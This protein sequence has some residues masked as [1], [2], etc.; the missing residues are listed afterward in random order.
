MNKSSDKKT[1]FFTIAGIVLFVI[2]LQGFASF[3]LS[4]INRSSVPIPRRVPRVLP[5]LPPAA[6]VS[7]TNN[8]MVLG[9]DG[10]LWAKGDNIGGGL[11]DNSEIP[12]RFFDQVG[13]DT[14][15]IS[16]S[17]GRDHTVAIKADGTLWAWG[18]NGREVIRNPASS[19]LGDGTNIN[20]LTPV[21]IGTDIDWAMVAAGTGH[22]VA[23]RAN[24]TLWFWGTKRLEGYESKRSLVP[25]QVGNDTDWAYIVAGSGGT[26]M[27]KIDGTLWAWGENKHGIMGHGMLGVGSIEVLPIPTQVAENTT[28]KA[29]DIGNLHS[30][31]IQTDGSLWAWGDNSQGNLGDGTREPSLYPIQIGTCTDWVSV[32]AGFG[33][34][35]ATREDGSLWVWGRHSLLFFGGLA[36]RDSTIPTQI[37]PYEHWVSVAAGGNNRAFA[38]TIDGRVQRLG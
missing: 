37:H 12:R 27:L 4:F 21:Q 36:Q 35:I 30:A 2:F 9:T 19:P 34:T 17:A 23:I 3:S 38:I 13:A 11:G 20:R 16:V 8:T 14:D 33:F 24:G 25:I 10:T 32:A 28:W 1:I 18:H 5:V 22:T 7:T 31:G 6:M 29:V 15:W 26:M